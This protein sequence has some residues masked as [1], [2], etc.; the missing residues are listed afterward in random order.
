[1]I[2]LKICVKALQQWIK[3]SE[4]G[5]NI[6]ESDPFYPAYKQLEVI[7][8]K[9]EQEKELHDEFDTLFVS[10]C[11]VIFDTDNFVWNAYGKDSLESSDNPL[12]N[13]QWLDFMG[14]NDKYY[15]LELDDG[16]HQIFND[17]CKRN[18]IGDYK[19]E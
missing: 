5:G 17:Y 9:L 10:G 13:E 1:M 16:H 7:E 18:K 2:P 12:T 19:D 3:E 8:D 6:D 15:Y 11:G 4:M 14:E